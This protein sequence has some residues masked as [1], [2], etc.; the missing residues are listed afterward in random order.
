L[1]R[2]LQVDAGYLLF[3]CVV[4]PY[5]HYVVAFAVDGEVAC[6]CKGVQDCALFVG[7]C[8]LAGVVDLSQYRDFVVLE[9]YV[10]DWDFCYVGGVYCVFDFVLC[11]CAGEPKQVDSAYYG[12]VYVA[13]FVYNIRLELGPGDVGWG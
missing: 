9:P 10:Y 6:H 8:V 3:A 4:F 7:H 11:L 12:V 5:E 13:V 1:V 2:V